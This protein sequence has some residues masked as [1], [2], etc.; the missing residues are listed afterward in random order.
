[1]WV[2]HYGDVKSQTLFREIRTTLEEDEIPSVTFASECADESILYEA[3]FDR[4]PDI[5]PPAAVGPV[6]GLV[7]DLEADY[8]LPILLA[9]LASLSPTDFAKL[10]ASVASIVVRHS[11]IANRNPNDLEN[12]LYQAARDIR[13]VRQ[14][15]GSSRA[16]LAA[17]KKAFS[18]IDPTDDQLKVALQDVHLAKR[19]ASYVLYTIAEKMQSATKAVTLK[20]NSIEHI[21][22][23][24]AGKNA[25]PDQQALAPFVWHLGNLSVLEETYNRDAGGKSFKDKVKFYEKTDIA[26]SKRIPLEH[27]KWD[28]DSIL[29]RA[30]AMHPL[31]V[32]IWPRLQV[33]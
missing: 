14:S 15:T 12:A 30:M 8:V 28:V 32:A 20:K 11:V 1:M 13:K 22:P 4:N 10:A 19:Q 31:I 24:N 26:M 25:W 6:T 18:G 16:S 29:K 7:H 33:K 3:I 23:E 21:Y 27:K 2:S 9:G 17:A 5:L